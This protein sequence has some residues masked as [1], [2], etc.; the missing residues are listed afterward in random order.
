M[1]ITN[2][3]TVTRWCRV[4]KHYYKGVDEDPHTHCAKH[5]DPECRW[6][7]AEDMQKDVYGGADD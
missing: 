1:P 2:A 7:A 5:D 6:C 4:G 3:H